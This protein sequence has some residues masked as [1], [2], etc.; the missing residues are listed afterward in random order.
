M[1]NMGV[2]MVL[3]GCRHCGGA[4]APEEVVQNEFRGV[5]H[6]CLQCSRAVYEDAPQQGRRAPA[7]TAPRGPQFH[8]RP[9]AAARQ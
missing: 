8:H 7:H 5:E 4:I 3:G 1:C 6:K 9:R 2:T